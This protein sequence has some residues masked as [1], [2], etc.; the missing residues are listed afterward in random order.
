MKW[1]NK[2]ACDVFTGVDRLFCEDSVSYLNEIISLTNAK[3]VITSNWRLKLSIDE[4]NTKFKERGV[5]GT[6]IDKTECNYNKKNTPIPVGNRGMEI[7]DWLLFNNFYTKYVVIDDQ[8]ADIS[9]HIPKSKILKV[10]PITGITSDIVDKAINI[11][12]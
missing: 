10:N 2:L 9:E 5:I 7:R 6:I 11:L 12:L 8:I 4:L 1:S 3:I